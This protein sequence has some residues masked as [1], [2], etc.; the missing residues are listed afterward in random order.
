MIG[1]SPV[2]HSG[3]RRSCAAPSRCVPVPTR[4]KQSPCPA[5]SEPVAG[6]TNPQDHANAGERV[7]RDL[8][9]A[10]EV[11]GLDTRSPVPRHLGR[12][13][14]TEPA[15]QI[16]PIRPGRR[17]R[18]SRRLQ[19]LEV[20]GD[21]LDRCAVRTKKPVRQP[22]IA[23]LDQTA[24]LRHHQRRQITRRLL[25][26]G[27]RQANAKPTESVTGLQ[28]SDSSVQSTGKRILLAP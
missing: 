13:K 6:S 11:S 23:G 20:L 26:S 4:H 1:P 22:L 25:L 14:K 12:P 3:N 9:P 8:H 17:R 27:H 18:P 15:Q 24:E 7:F 21:R 19:V 28:L 10:A 2:H 16:H 5:V